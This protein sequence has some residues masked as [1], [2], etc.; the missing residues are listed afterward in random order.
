[1]SGIVYFFTH[2][3]LILQD[4]VF[5]RATR[6]LGLSPVAVVLGTHDFERAQSAGVFHDVYDLT[7]GFNPGTSIDEQ[8]VL[9]RL[10]VL[11]RSGGDDSMVQ[12][13]VHDRWLTKRFDR[14]QQLGYAAHL[15]RRFD[16]L[17][18][19]GPPCAMVGEWT[20][21]H[22]R[23]ARCRFF[24]SAPYYYPVIARFWQRFYLEDDLFWRWRECVQTFERY[25]R[26]GPPA[27][28]EEAA[29]LVVEGIRERAAQPAA[30][31][32]MGRF[33]SPAAEPLWAKLSGE[34]LRRNFEYWRDALEIHRNPFILQSPVEMLPPV[35][36]GRWAVE[37]FRRNWIT[38]RQLQAAPPGRRYAA[39]FLH[40]QPEYTVDTLGYPHS[41]QLEWVRLV[42]QSLPA[43]VL[44]LVKEQQ[45]MMGQRP[46]AFYRNLLSLP[47]V[48]L[49]AP[50]VN[51]RALTRDSCAVFTLSGT[52]GLEGMVLGVPTFIFCPIFYSQFDGIISVC[53][54]AELRQ[55]VHAALHA[56][57]VA[58]PEAVRAAIAAM[59]SASAP[60]QLYSLVL[61]RDRFLRDENVERLRASFSQLLSEALD[62]RQ[63]SEGSKQ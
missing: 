15:L 55:Q 11:E 57:A 27:E 44:L 43:D 12:A 60:G 10:A 45:F 6:E 31:D 53:D 18:A 8:D 19:N 39:L 47:N 3:G 34:R 16:E 20:M 24:S 38:V 48:R 14:R 30:F 7:V 49:V 35:K 62:R 29:Q 54:P 59:Y 51:G 56:H 58:A 1:M 50:E 41:N 4:A 17:E 2:S 46:L 36:V 32:N 63:T 22:H 9:A 37:W 61:D 26:E 23:M 42:A 28:A 13:L 40:Y 52:V 5:A 21:L 33:P 25:R